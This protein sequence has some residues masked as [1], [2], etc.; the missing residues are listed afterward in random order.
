MPDTAQFE[1]RPLVTAYLPLRLVE[2]VRGEGEREARF[3]GTVLV[4]DIAGY[5]AL[6]EGFGVHGEDGIES[7][8]QFLS[9]AFSRYLDLVQSSGGEVVY[10]AGDAVV[11]YWPALD[12]DQATAARRAALCARRMAETPPAGEAAPPLHLG[13]ASGE[14]WAAKIGGWSGRWSLLFGGP[15]TRAAF[16][17]AK[18]SRAGQTWMTESTAELLAGGV[19]RSPWSYQVVRGDGRIDQAASELDLAAAPIQPLP[20][21]AT[22][23][24]LPPAIEV[25]AEIEDGQWTSERRRIDC[26]FLRLPELDES[27]PGALAG[28]RR[29]LFILHD[30]LL[31]SSVTGRL[32]IDERGLTLVWV[33]GEPLAAYR[34]SP[35]NSLDLASRLTARLAEAGF[36]PVAGLAS[37]RAFCSTVGGLHRREP[38]VLGLPMILAARLMEHAQEGLLATGFH[39]DQAPVG[40]ALEPLAPLS[41]K[42]LTVP[43][44]AAH[45]IRVG[46]SGAARAPEPPPGLVARAE[47]LGLLEG[48]LEATIGGEGGLAVIVGPPGMGK[49][50]LLETFVEHARGRGLSCAMGKAFGAERR[51]TYFVWRRVFRQLFPELTLDQPERLR[52]QLATLVERLGVGPGLA[53]LLNVVFPAALP[54]SPQ[55]GGMTAQVRA[56]ATRDLLLSLL[57]EGAAR[58][59]V[60]TIEDL[61]QT[62]SASLRLLE[63]AVRRLPGTLFVATVRPREVNDVTD[64]IVRSARRHIELVPLDTAQVS[65]LAAARVGLR[66][67]PELA[68]LIRKKADG[69]PFYA[70]E[71]LKHLRS[72]VPEE[73]RSQL[74]T[75][76]PVGLAALIAAPDQDAGVLA[77]SLEGLTGASIRAAKAAAVIG[78]RFDLG[79]L[80]AALGPGVDELLAAE[81]VQRLEQ[82]GIVMAAPAGESGFRFAHALMQAACYDT[83]PVKH[84]KQ[85]HR[86]IA[87][88]LEGADHDRDD[89]RLF[90]LVHHHH[91]AGNGER[92]IELGEVA[93]LR[94]LRHGGY[95]EAMRF[96]DLCLESLPQAPAPGQA[97]PRVRW[98]RLKAE[99]AGGA[100]DRETRR[101]E[102][103]TAVVLAGESVGPLGVKVPAVARLLV[104]AARPV[105]RPAPAAAAS[106]ELDREL[107]QSFRQL[108]IGAYFSGDSLQV[109]YSTTRALGF[110]E[111]LGESPELADCLASMGMCLGLAGFPG[112]GRRHLE[113]AGTLAE[114]LAHGASTIYAHLTL[115]LFLVGRGEWEEA[116]EHAARCQ[117]GS[118]QLGDTASWGNAQALRFWIAHYRG[119]LAEAQAAAGT[120]RQAGEACGNLQHQ[121]WA[122]R[123][124]GLGH[125]RRGEWHEART[126]LTRA[127]E[128]FAEAERRIEGRAIYE[129][130]PLLGDLG[131]TWLALG[132]RERAIELCGQALDT[133]LRARRPP[134]HATLEGCSSIAE[135]FVTLTRDGDE[136]L[137]HADRAVALLHQYRRAFPI[138][139]PRHSLWRGWLLALRGKPGS[140]RAVWSAGIETAR[141]LGMDHDVERLTAAIAAPPRPVVTGSQRRAGR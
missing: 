34:T 120:L 27:A 8:G 131:A 54:E 48:E 41:L 108:A 30:T 114:R 128:L 91:L 90:Q 11:S 89:E 33:A 61:H 56:A 59:P 17:A 126:E 94:A 82:Q 24:L 122:A 92:L 50:L 106:R 35:G 15:A 100:G 112:A 72:A 117:E 21:L 49:S 129:L 99:A 31:T 28:F 111:R 80:T 113:A 57:A 139:L 137:R 62:D 98:H 140:A 107:A 37:G 36:R 88:A 5:A 52:E 105:T 127:R 6:T 115:C 10:L 20:A 63:L 104:R 53:P 29:A 45:V 38:V 110:A 81:L 64:R 60:I 97:D 76:L 16:R 133:L 22:E 3:A 79:L 19:P 75:T 68:E 93:A 73:R 138:G 55:T 2:R 96:L 51:V 136:Q 74:V 125:I 26:L 134:G 4:V 44:Q 67:G 70:L 46:A 18:A 43:V 116:E 9:Q 7:L 39:A 87:A 32:V 66:L 121:C 42:G 102:A 119:R 1:Q 86:K 118:R 141:S 124:T 130:V 47:A 65:E 14:L 69:N 13:L 58:A 135:T 77:R 12:E 132:Q 101:H 78:E 95:R 25:R 40:L 83:I 103:L 123:F 23:E 109:A 85:L 71:Y 84:R